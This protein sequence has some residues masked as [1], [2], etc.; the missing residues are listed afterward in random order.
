MPLVPEKLL[1][2]PPV[3][4]QETIMAE[5]AILYALGIG[6]TELE[7]LYERRLRILPTMAAVLGAPASSWLPTDAG[8]TRTRMMH[9][10]TSLILHAPLQPGEEIRAISTV[11][12]I[13]DKGT[14]KGA[15]L[16]LNRELTDTTGAPLATVVMGIFLRAD[17]GFGGTREGAPPPHA[18]PGRAPDLRETRT[19]FATQ[20]A[21]YRLSGD[22]NP[23]HIDPRAAAKLNLSRPILHGMATLGIAG[24]A[25]MQALAD[26]MPERVRRLDA[27]FSAPVYPGE[28]I[29][30]DIW[31][32]GPGR[33][34]FRCHV[35]ERGVKVLD[36]GRFEW[37]GTVD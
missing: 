29:I 6:A 36:N 12:P 14:E 26:N 37:N 22:M 19:T 10:E 7:F 33:A 20:A 23:L 34:A 24:R 25:L 32:E 13:V 30:T 21:L 16:Y 31:C 11:G 8:I 2:L 4:T 18:I 3:E 27:R 9:G 1:G 15:I 17:G 5:R 35:A 28:T